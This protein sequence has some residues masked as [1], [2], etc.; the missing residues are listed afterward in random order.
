MA[1]ELIKEE[2][3]VS[4]RRKKIGRERLEIQANSSL[5]KN[6]LMYK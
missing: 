3:R 1:L 2:N 4:R 5:E 6:M